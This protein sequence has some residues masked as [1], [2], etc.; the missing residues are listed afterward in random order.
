[1]KKFATPFGIGEFSIQTA[2]CVLL[3]PV[4]F[5]AAQN[6]K[7]YRLEIGSQTKIIIEATDFNQVEVQEHPVDSLFVFWQSDGE[8]APYLNL[9]L[10]SEAEAIRIKGSKSLWFPDYDDKLSAHKVIAQKLL[11]YLPAGLNLEIVA[12]KARVDVGGRYRQVNVRTTTGDIRLWPFTGHAE[13]FSYQGDLSIDT[14]NAQ[15]LCECPLKWIDQQAEFTI[16]L[17]TVNGKT[18]ALNNK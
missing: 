14:G 15:I 2:F 1:M 8:Y 12:D 4:Y 5:L 3:F 16:Q 9:Q 17:K 7:N 6:T 10:T 11:V 18:K 13:L